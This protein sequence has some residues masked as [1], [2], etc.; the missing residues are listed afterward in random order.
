MIVFIVALIVFLMNIPFGYW[1]EN[2][3]K[4]SVQWAFAIHLPI[5][6][7]ILMRIYSGMGFQLYTYPILVGAFFF[8]QLLGATIHKKRRSM[9][10]AALSSC[11]IM[12][13]IRNDS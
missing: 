1:R 8:G 9:N 4:F 2:V 11:L 10:K 13:L 3:K 12:D 5:P 6:F 7:I